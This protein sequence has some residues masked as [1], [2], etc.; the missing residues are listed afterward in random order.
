MDTNLY[1][2]P[3]QLMSYN[4]I[5]NFVIGAR[6]LGKSYAFKK[7]PIKNF[8]NK[9]EQFVYLRRY[10]TDLKKIGNYFLDIEQEFP[11]HELKVKG[12]EFKIDGKQ[13]GWAIPLSSWLSEKSTAYP[14]VTTI[15][16][17]EFLIEKSNTHYLKNEVENFLNLL[18]TIIRTRDNVRVYCLSNATTIV[19]PYF[20]YFNLVPDVNKRFNGFK[21]AVIEIPKSADFVEERKK[22]KFGQLINGTAYADMSLDNQFTADSDTFIQKKTEGA[23]FSCVFKHNGKRMGLWYDKFLDEFTV[24]KKYNPNCPYVFTVNQEDIEEGVQFVKNYKTCLP[25]LRMAFAFKDNA[26]SFEDLEIRNYMY[27]IFKKINIF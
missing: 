1:Y 15:I 16:F 11:D 22:T 12:K 18:D 19:N 25:L 3:Q 23:E 20:I 24:S 14:K 17:D 5:L 21:N 9:G 2:N 10:K 7:V 6:G 13:A 4:R 8:I 26:L 27:E